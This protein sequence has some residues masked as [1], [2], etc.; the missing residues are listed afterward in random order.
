[1]SPSVSTPIKQLL[2]PFS[3]V[4][5]CNRQSQHTFFFLKFQPTHNKWLC[6][7]SF[8]YMVS[9]RLFPRWNLNGLYMYFIFIHTKFHMISHA[10]MYFTTVISAKFHKIIWW[11][12]YSKPQAYYLFCITPA[13]LS[14]CYMCHNSHPG[15]LAP[16]SPG[17]PQHQLFRQPPP[18]QLHPGIYRSL[19]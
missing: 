17:H 19:T 12:L 6:L 4:F 2:L 16:I 13:C 14:S 3:A 15:T 18:P 9:Y 5:P 8:L 1:M 7:V 10:Y 11:F